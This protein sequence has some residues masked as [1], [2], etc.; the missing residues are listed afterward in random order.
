MDIEP[1]SSDPIS[2]KSFNLTLL[3]RTKGVFEPFNFKVQRRVTSYYSVG[4]FTVRFG[5][6][7]TQKYNQTGNDVLY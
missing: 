6:V 3:K 7:L 2:S 5:P 1:N 4:V